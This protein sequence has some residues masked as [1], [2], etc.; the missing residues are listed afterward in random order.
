M[1]CADIFISDAIIRTVNPEMELFW[2]IYRK[3]KKSTGQAPLEL[4]FWKTVKHCRAQL[5]PVYMLASRF[6]KKTAI[7]F[8]L[9]LPK[10][11]TLS[12]TKKIL[13]PF[14]S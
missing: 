6:F 14:F 4:K 10:N 11:R 13:V 1:Y 3:L 8:V 5:I 7:V 2:A 12:G 9:L